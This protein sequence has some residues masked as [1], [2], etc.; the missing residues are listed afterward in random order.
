MTI[1]AAAEQVVQTLAVFSH[2]TEVWG[3]GGLADD[4]GPKLTCIETDALVALLVALGDE[5]AADRWLEGHAAG[6]DAGDS[7]YRGDD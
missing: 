4:V 3:D 5:G 1:E 6:D 2:F 7:H